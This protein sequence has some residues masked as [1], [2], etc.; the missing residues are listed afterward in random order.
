MRSAAGTPV[1]VF[2]YFDYVCP[3]SYL[4][5][6]LLEAVHA[7]QPLNVVWRPLEIRP[8]GGEADASAAAD[9]AGQS[10]WEELTEKAAALGVPLY[11]PA[12]VPTSHLAHQATQFARDLGPEAH[13]RL[14]LAVFR[15]HF[16]RRIDIGRQENLV[17][18]ANEEGIDRQGLERALEDGR[19]LPEL[20]VAEQE[21]K[22]YGIAQTPTF[23]FGRFK[24]IGTAPLEVLRDAAQR[25]AA[26]I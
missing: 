20:A 14:H 19:Y 22:R 9:A 5:F 8:E 23:L 24:I 16:V 1:D 7:D 13:R 2:A 6:Y 17:L 26:E 4:A 18:L 25:A 15:A 21:A 3:H 12:L 11:R 10:R